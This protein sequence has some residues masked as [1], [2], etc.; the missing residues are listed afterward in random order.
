M[1]ELLN[2]PNFEEYGAPP[3]SETFPD[4]FF[5]EDPPE[6]LMLKRPV[7]PYENEAKE[8]C[9]KCPYRLACLK[10]AMTDP[11][12]IGIWGGLT[13]KE[14]AALKRGTR[15]ASVSFKNRHR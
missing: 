7:Y 5:P 12:L 10:Y 11:S 1:S 2:S 14:R 15:D 8:V 3:C 9:A 4:M 6:G 13:E